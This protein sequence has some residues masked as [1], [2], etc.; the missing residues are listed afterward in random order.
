M[1]NIEKF[2]D[3]INKHYPNENLTVLDYKG[4]KDS[5]II[6]C[7]S[8]GRIYNYACSGGLLSS[9]KKILCHDC[10]DKILQKEKFEQKIQK[11]FCS[12]DLTIVSF[13]G[14]NHS[15]VIKCNRCGEEYSFIKPAYIFRKTRDYFCLKCFPPKNE[16]M[17]KTR[18]KFKDFIN[19]SSNWELAQDISFIHSNDLVECKCLY[20]GRINKKNIYDYM[21]GRGCFCQCNT[22]QKTTEDFLSELDDD[23]ELIGEYKSAFTKVT[24]R[25]KSCGFIYKVTPHNYLTGKRCPRCSRMESKGERKIRQFLEDKNIPYIKEYPE[26]IDGHNLRFDFYLPKQQLYIEYQGEQ[27]YHPIDYFGGEERFL[28]QCELDKKKRD[29]AGDKLIEIKYDEDVESILISTLKIN[30]YPE[31]E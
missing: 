5:C 10:Q 7:E 27:H 20:C 28:I 26:K 29:F 23:Y 22:E 9:K 30:D 12:D 3:K 4:A 13:T 21:R 2:Q 15:C 6:R 14:N 11:C 1:I 16:L 25:H 8:C 18:E 24:L 31:R 17:E 19:N